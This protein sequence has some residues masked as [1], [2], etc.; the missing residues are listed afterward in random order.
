MPFLNS[1]I[2]DNGLSALASEGNRLD[3]CSSEPTTYTEATSTNSLANK[4]S[5]SIGAPANRSPSGRKVTIAA[6]TD[7]TATA[8][9][10]ATHYAI[11]DT[12]NSRLLV[13]NALSSGVSLTN[14]NLFTLTAFDVGIPGV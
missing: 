3:L 9:G 2:L 11:V 8:T 10:T 12:V 14:G 4:T 5:I 6:I 7:G 13:A 1:R